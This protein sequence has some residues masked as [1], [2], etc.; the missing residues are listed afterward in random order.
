MANPLQL[1][2]WRWVYESELW[3]VAFVEDPSR[4]DSLEVTSC[5]Q[6]PV[7]DPLKVTSLKRPPWGYSLDVIPWRWPSWWNL[8]K[9]NP[10]GSFKK[11]PSEDDFSLARSPRILLFLSTLT[12]FSCKR[13]HSWVQTKT[14]RITKKYFTKMLDIGKF[15]CVT[16]F[17]LKL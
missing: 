4:S 14:E 11:W 15:K 9:A 5:C 2:P 13:T 1:T 3:E 6:L 17:I 7:G 10:W 16:E 8:L 12:T